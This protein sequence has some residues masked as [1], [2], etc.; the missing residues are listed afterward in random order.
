VHYPVRKSGVG[1]ADFIAKLATEED[2]Y[3]V[4]LVNLG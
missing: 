3:R 4:F 2:S 1:P